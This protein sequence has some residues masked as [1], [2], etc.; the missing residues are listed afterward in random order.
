MPGTCGGTHGSGEG[1][2]ATLATICSPTGV[3]VDQAGN[4]YIID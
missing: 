1:G 4:V 3:A 2:P